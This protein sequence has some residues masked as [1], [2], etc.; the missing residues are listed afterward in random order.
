MD[1]DLALSI[2]IIPPLGPGPV[3]AIPS[4]TPPIPVNPDRLTLHEVAQMIDFREEVSKRRKLDP[5]AVS[6]KLLVQAYINEKKVQHA[7]GGRTG[8]FF[9]SVFC[10]MLYVTVLFFAYVCVSGLLCLGLDDACNGI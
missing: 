6:D 2:V 9:L 1:A 5:A 3:A 10:N 7:F 8:S 4:I